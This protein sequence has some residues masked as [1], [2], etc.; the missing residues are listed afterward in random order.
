MSI[1][2]KPTSVIWEFKGFDDGY[3]FKKDNVWR[4]LSLI[5]CSACEYAY[6]RNM[7]EILTHNGEYEFNLINMTMW[8][9]TNDFISP[10]V[11]I[12]RAL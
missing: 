10:Y 1:I 6:K 2:I 12:R 3:L 8:V 11:Q 5:N 4:K 9:N 7:D